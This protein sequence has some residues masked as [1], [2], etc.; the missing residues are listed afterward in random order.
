M[1]ALG[2]DMEAGT[3]IEWHVAPGDAVRRGDVVASVDTSKAEMDVESFYDGEV[4]RLLIEPGDRVPVGTPIATV[5]EAGRPAAPRSRRGV[6]PEPQAEAAVPSPADAA[7]PAPAPRLAPA[8][9]P[10]P[11]PPTQSDGRQRVSPLARRVAATLGID[12]ADV[13]GSGR[14][15]AVTRAD[16]ELAA[17]RR[18]E[19]QAVGPPAP[20]ERP[21]DEPQR[22]DHAA[23]PR[24][25]APLAV[26]PPPPPAPSAQPSRPPLADRRDTM[27]ATTAT[28]MAR[29]K[30]EIP[31]YYLEQEIELTA[32]L[33]WLADRNAEL[34]PA[35]RMIPAVLL[36]GATA[37]AARE[38]PL[39]NG[40]YLDG[41]PRAADRVDLGVAISLRGGGLVAPALHD[42]DRAT[43]EAMM[44][45][46]GELTLRARQGR[47][48]ASEMTDATL[49]VTSLGDLGADKVHGVI[50]PPQLALVGFGSIRERPWAA[51]GL[52]G[53]RPTVVATLAADHRASDGAQGSRLL[54]RIDELLQRPE[55][56]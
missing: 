41:A 6:A 19:A 32:A 12:P 16:V 23:K 8:P 34:R 3:L 10:A 50:H 2:A 52:V 48:K 17:G 37:R 22:P 28:L 38:H 20:S 33:D 5:R 26:P 11:A 45:A 40:F 30:R 4:E 53:A 7:A 15:R 9:P 14:G 18:A 42:A 43:P 47:L 13:T 31:H 46:L 36:L 49:T 56:W 21:A 54:A 55:E 25:S 35:A 29:S 39:L 24:T 44:A 1:P 27:R 51:N